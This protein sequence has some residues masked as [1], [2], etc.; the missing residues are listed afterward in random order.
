MA[1]IPV[2]MKLW[3]QIIF[4]RNT[5]FQAYLCLDWGHWRS[6]NSQRTPSHCGVQIEKKNKNKKK[7]T[8]LSFFVVVSTSRA[9]RLNLKLL[10]I[11]VY[12]QV[13]QIVCQTAD[14]NSKLKY[15]SLV[16]LCAKKKE[17]IEMGYWII[18]KTNRV[19]YSNIRP[20]SQSHTHTQ[21]QTQKFNLRTIR[22]EL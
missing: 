13:Y 9:I 6:V 14:F 1:R 20:E 8:Y 2:N 12:N 3:N 10:H 15:C 18:K 19:N 5:L 11:C 21:T 17:F 4:K 22:V 7:E 16:W